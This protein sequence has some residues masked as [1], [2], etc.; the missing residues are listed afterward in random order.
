VSFELTM[1]GGL[2]WWSWVLW[3]NRLSKLWGEV[4]EQR[5][6]TASASAPASRFLHSLRICLGFP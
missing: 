2:D 4:S 5:P 3:A 6:S 1:D